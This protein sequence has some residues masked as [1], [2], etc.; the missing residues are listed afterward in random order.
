MSILD[1]NI[2]SGSIPK[3]RQLLNIL[4]SRILSGELQPD[5]QLP[6]EDILINTYNLSRGTVRKAIDQLEAEKLIR[7]EHGIGSFVRSQPSRAIPF[8]FPENISSTGEISYEI[9]SREIV[10]VP[11]NIAEKL[12]LT[13]GDDVCHIIQ[14]QRSED[15]VL[16]YTMRYIPLGFCPDIMKYDLRKQSMHEFLVFISEIPLLRAELEIQA[17]LLN[18]EE[19]QLLEISA[20][21]PAIEINRMTYAAPT[22]PAIW[23]QGIF[24]EK[25]MLGIKVSDLLR[26]KI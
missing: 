21:T 23:Y 15:E 24:K 12:R 18:E 19:A 6:T 1:S 2:T 11:V 10:P 3:Y 26:R 8:F 13:P 5:D 7:K 9:I 20:G 16:A 17:R 14:K 4:R 25:C 22:K